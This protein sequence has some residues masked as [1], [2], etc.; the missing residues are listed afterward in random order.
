MSPAAVTGYLKR[1]IL[2]DQHTL[3][4]L[5]KGEKGLHELLN[6]TAIDSFRDETRAAIEECANQIADTLL[7]RLLVDTA[8]SVGREVD[9]KQ[10][11]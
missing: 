10:L 5:L 4:K 1:P 6:I 9:L 11:V 2:E 7:A 3:V 8:A